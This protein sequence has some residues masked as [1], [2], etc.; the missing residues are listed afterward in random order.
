MGLLVSVSDIGKDTYDVANHIFR[1]V[2][3]GLGWATVGAN[4]VFAAVTGTSIASASVFTKVAVPGDAQARLQAALSPSASS[5]GSSVLGMLI[6]PSL[7]LILYG[8]LSETSIG[9]LFIAGIIPGLV[10]CGGLLH[11][12]LD[13][14]ALVPEPRRRARR[15]SSERST[16]T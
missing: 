15:R 2:K 8:I 16:R 14:G 13:H 7:L 9:D 5:P 3:A 6:P 11:A 4:A 12:D 10:L 1:S